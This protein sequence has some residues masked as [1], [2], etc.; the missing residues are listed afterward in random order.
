MKRKIIKIII[1]LLLIMVFFLI[2]FLSIW[3]GPT[4]CPMQPP[5]GERTPAATQV[6]A[7]TGEVT[8]LRFSVV[9]RSFY[10]FRQSAELREKVYNLAKDCQLLQIYYGYEM[11]GVWYDIPS[12]N[13]DLKGIFLNEGTTGA[14]AAAGSHIVEI[15]QYILICVFAQDFPNITYEQG[16]V[17]DS[18]G[19]EFQM[20]FLEYHCYGTMDRP[21]VPYGYCAEVTHNFLFFSIPEMYCSSGFEERLYFIL[22]KDSIPDDYV[23]TSGWAHKLTAEDIWRILE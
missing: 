8:Q 23:L 18:L 16:D 10:Y 1:V 2:T 20:P 4:E 9:P 22:E 15:G 21:I 7:F 3:L 19:T 5:K 17:Y 6:P 14:E 11:D 12:E 13:F